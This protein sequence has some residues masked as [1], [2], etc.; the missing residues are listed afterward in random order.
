MKIFYLP[1]TSPH[2]KIAQ[3]SFLVTLV[4]PSILN[5]QLKYLLLCEGFHSPTLER[6]QGPIIPILCHYNTLSLTP[7]NYIAE[8]LLIYLSVPHHKT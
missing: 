2:L 8:L 3:H 6:I 4:F 5:T 7:Y 1:F